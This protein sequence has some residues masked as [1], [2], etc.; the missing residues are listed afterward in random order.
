MPAELRK[1]HKA[2][3]KAVMAA[4]DFKASMTESEIVGELFKMYA[5]VA[6]AT[7]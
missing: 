2:N 1:A 3:D 7:S 6:K 5:Q 4:Y